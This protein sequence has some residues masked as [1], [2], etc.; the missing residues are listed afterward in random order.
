MEALLREDP[1][2]FERGYATRWSFS[3]KISMWLKVGLWLHDRRVAQ[4]G[5]QTGQ[6]VDIIDQK[7]E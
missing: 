7:A 3:P 2:P 5:V 6:N 1:L 4:D